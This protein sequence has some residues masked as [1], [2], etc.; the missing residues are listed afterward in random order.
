[1]W[2]RARRRASRYALR[3]GNEEDRDA[4]GSPEPANGEE[5]LHD[6]LEIDPNAPPAKRNA[7]APVAEDEPA[8]DQGDALDRNR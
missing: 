7:D 4:E 5:A 2:V 3:V 6:H 8:K 1:M